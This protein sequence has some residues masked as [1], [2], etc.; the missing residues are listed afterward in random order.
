MP[1]GF[2]PQFDFTAPGKTPEASKKPDLRLVPNFDDE[3]TDITPELSFSDDELYPGKKKQ[4][5]SFFLEKGAY[6]TTVLE[7]LRKL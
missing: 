6:A 5:I 3:H 1:E 7:A 2:R 4:I